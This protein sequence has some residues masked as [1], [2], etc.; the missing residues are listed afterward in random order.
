MD[1]EGR[2]I[3]EHNLTNLK[4]KVRFFPAIKKSSEL[5]MI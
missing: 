1:S 2:E 5:I 3:R 4:T